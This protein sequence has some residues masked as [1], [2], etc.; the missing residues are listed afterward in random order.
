MRA[1]EYYCWNLLQ[2]KVGEVL[3]DPKTYRRQTAL[4]NPKSGKQV[5]ISLSKFEEAKPQ[6]KG[7]WN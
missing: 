3:H 4:I 6:Q 2:G 7:W 1:F 5:S